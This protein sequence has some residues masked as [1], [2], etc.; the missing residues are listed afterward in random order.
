MLSGIGRAGIWHQS[1]FFGYRSAWKE[2]TTVA[3]G[4]SRKNNVKWAM[5]ETNS[6]VEIFHGEKLFLPLLITNVGN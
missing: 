5:P 4:T 1:L 3:V 2:L 6:Y